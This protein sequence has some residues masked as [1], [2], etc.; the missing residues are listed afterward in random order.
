MLTAA[1]TSAIP[2]LAWGQQEPSLPPPPPATVTV[3]PPWQTAPPPPPADAYSPTAYAQPRPSVPPGVRY[4]PSPGVRWMLEGL[5]GFGMAIG[6]AL[7]GGLIGY[8][9]D[10]G[11]SSSFGVSM[12][13]L[14]GTAMTFGFPLGV[15]L[16]G[17][18]RGGN[19]GYGWS[20]LGTFGGF[21]VAGLVTAAIVGE[22]SGDCAGGV[23]ATSVLSLLLPTAGAVIAYELSN[24]QNGLPAPTGS[25]VRLAPTLQFGQGGALAGVGATF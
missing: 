7:G 15:L 25:R 3:A 10:R 19:G 2:G 23:A 18:A 17:H 21:L 5:G 11:S 9:I 24:D 20:L 6:F 12:V 16:V 14:G 13:L 1:L 22:C 4:D 8:A